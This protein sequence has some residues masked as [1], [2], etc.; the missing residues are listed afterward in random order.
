M[1]PVQAEP[2]FTGLVAGAGLAL[3]ALDG[4]RDYKKFKR[5]EDRKKLQGNEKAQGDVITHEDH[6]L[7]AGN[8]SF[9]LKNKEA[10]IASFKNFQ[11]F[12]NYYCKE[13][14]MK[15]FGFFHVG[16]GLM[17]A[18]LLQ[19]KAGRDYEGEIAKINEDHLNVH[20]RLVADV[21]QEKTIKLAEGILSEDKPQAWVEGIKEL[22]QCIIDLEAQPPII[23]LRNEER[24]ELERLRQKSEDLDRQV[25]QLQKDL[26]EKQDY[27]DDFWSQQR[28]LLALQEK[29]RRANSLLNSN[30]PP[31]PIRPEAKQVLENKIKELEAEIRKLNQQLRTKPKL[32]SNPRGRGRGISRGRGRGALPSIPTRVDTQKKIQVIGETNFSDKGS[33]EGEKEEED[34]NGI[35]S[36]S[37]RSNLPR[38]SLLSPSSSSSSSSS[39]NSLELTRSLL[40]Q[41]SAGDFKLKSI[42]KGSQTETPQSLS[43][44][45]AKDCLKRVEKNNSS[46]RQSPDGL[47]IPDA[48]RKK[49]N[50]ET[51]ATESGL[52]LADQWHEDARS[53][54]IRRSREAENMKEEEKKR[55]EEEEVKRLNILAPFRDTELTYDLYNKILAHA[56]SEFILAYLSLNSE[57]K[58][59]IS[60]HK[61]M[62]DQELEST[63]RDQASMFGDAAA[64]I[65]DTRDVF[66]SR[67]LDAPDDWSSDDEV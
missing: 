44:A 57:K 31:L 19:A 8:R 3:F 28:E 56:E 23:P 65:R 38:S 55:K 13:I 48:F 50:Q 60:Q 40:S 47:S 34:S 62:R 14:P 43:V 24:D 22:N 33:K 32:A 51:I 30:K 35:F 66:S 52:F 4:S 59:L 1:R 12:F 26:F 41:I 63:Q 36:L 25:L 7:P 49:A 37:P 58:E 54:E 11:Q 18:S 45:E 42:E 21:K 15:K 64:K 2:W 16:L 61:V 17:A 6:A 67:V 53:E 29:Y 27:E 39:A 5:H 10:F 20:K 46:D 9:L